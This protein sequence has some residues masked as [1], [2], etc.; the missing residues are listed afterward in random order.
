[1]YDRGTYITKEEELMVS[2]NTMSVVTPKWRQALK[3]VSSFSM[4]KTR[5][6]I[7]EF[8]A[9]QMLT[10]TK[11]M[12]TQQ[13]NV[14]SKSIFSTPINQRMLLGEL[15]HRHFAWPNDTSAPTILHKP[16]HASL[17]FE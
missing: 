10:T 7:E 14:E 6:P 4:T 5:N 3:V 16:S 1:M 2:E 12:R 17:W 11:E 13:R 15:R 8:D 9:M